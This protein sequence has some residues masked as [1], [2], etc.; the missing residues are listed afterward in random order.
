MDIDNLILSKN[1]INTERRESL[2]YIAFIKFLA[3][4]IIIK[5]HLY[6]WTKRP[7]DYGARMCEIL[8]VAS[9]FL[10]GYNHYKKK[11]P[12]NYEESF[13]YSYKH[14]R[15]F[16]P[17]ELIN[18]IYGYYI[19]KGK[20]YDLT[21]FEILILNILMLKPWS[22]YSLLVGRF[23]GITWFLTDL[24]FC[25]FLTPLLLK[26]I[27]N[28]KNS[29]LLFF[30]I[31]F[32]RVATEEVIFHGAFNIFDAEFHR[33]PIIRLLEFYMGMLLTP[34]FFY[35]KN[36][37]DKCK[38]KL[39]IKIIFTY[40]QIVLPIIIYLIMLKY[41]NLFLRCYFVLIFCFFVFII[42]YDFGILSDLFAHKLCV[43]IMSCQMEM[44]LFQ[45][46]IYNIFLHSIIKKEFALMF[47]NKQIQFLIKLSMIFICGFL[48]KI[49]FKEKFAKI[50]DII[51]LRKKI[52][53]LN[54][55]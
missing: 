21:E 4:I 8:F 50:L 51:F 7:I 24:L 16:Y 15:S 52:I 20:K 53:N 41:N 54:I 28:I 13:N 2:N 38:N 42:S 48:Y 39:L 9:G 5:W 18:I 55:K 11:M 22:R 27:K 14:L 35:F 33:G 36:I 49:L 31:S 19:Y 6:F 23:N 10:V 46:A 47:N 17:L 25:Y 32:I 26:G 30:I 3:M 29:V 44:F 40:I 45:K 43:K 1:K 37:I 12:C 34:M